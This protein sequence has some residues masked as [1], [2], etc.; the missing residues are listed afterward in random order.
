MNRDELSLY[1]GIMP[2]K[3]HR[4]KDISFTYS[5]SPALGMEGCDLH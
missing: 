4:E 2:G 1:I 5:H 3:T